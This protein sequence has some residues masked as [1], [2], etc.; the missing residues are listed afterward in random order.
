ME[1]KNFLDDLCLGVKG[2]LSRGI[3][4]SPRKI[5]RYRLGKFS[6]GGRVLIGLGV[7]LDYQTLLNFEYHKLL[8][9][10]VVIPC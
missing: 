4:G 10:E 7:L 9:Q 2:Q 6:C 5:F 8:S 1:V 3:V